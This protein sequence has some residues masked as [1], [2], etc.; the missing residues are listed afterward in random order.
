MSTCVAGARQRPGNQSSSSSSKSHRTTGVLRS[1]SSRKRERERE[2]PRVMMIMTMLHTHC[3]VLRC[4]PYHYLPSSSSSSLLLLDESCVRDW[5]TRSC[6]QWAKRTN[7]K[8]R[9]ERTRGGELVSILFSFDVL[10]DMFLSVSRNSIPSFK[11]QLTDESE[12]RRKRITTRR[13]R[14][15]PKGLVTLCVMTQLYCT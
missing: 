10:M 15:K 4:P 14:E 5:C 11:W 9:R 12:R 3:T 8:E 7:K 6:N 1:F 13:E 2:T